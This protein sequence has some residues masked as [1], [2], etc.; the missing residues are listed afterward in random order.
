M[1]HADAARAAAPPAPPTSPPSARAAAQRTAQQHS[2]SR[3]GA[4]LRRHTGFWTGAAVCGAPPAARALGMINDN[5]LITYG[6]RAHRDPRSRRR[7]CGRRRVL[8]LYEYGC[9]LCVYGVWRRVHAAMTGAHTDAPRPQPPPDGRAAPGAPAWATAGRGGRGRGRVRGGRGG[10]EAVKVWGLGGFHPCVYVY[11]CV[12]CRSRVRRLLYCRCYDALR[13]MMAAV[14]A[15]PRPCPAPAPAGRLR[16][17]PL[18]V[19][20]G[21]RP[22]PPPDEAA[23]RPSCQWPMARRAELSV[24]RVKKERCVQPSVQR[25]SNQQRATMPLIDMCV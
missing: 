16:R 21:A 14:A 22:P 23:R 19:P 24:M 2:A 8:K 12:G 3:A 7:V 10:C 6:E 5:A 9:I 18:C 25:I 20:S 17:A 1:R 15:P 4:L 11:T 13:W